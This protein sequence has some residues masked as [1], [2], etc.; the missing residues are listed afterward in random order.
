LEA[1]D[2]GFDSQGTDVMIWNLTLNPKS[3]TL[4]T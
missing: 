2:T 3:C 4:Y 1:Q